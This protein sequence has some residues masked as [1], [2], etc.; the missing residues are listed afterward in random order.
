MPMTLN[1]TLLAKLV[2]W[3][4]GRG[5]QTLNVPDEGS[6]WTVA[7]TVDRADAL[8]CLVWEMTLRR[9]TP[10]AGGDA[11]ALRAWADQAA[12][13]ARGLL[14]MLKVVEVDPERD[15]AIVRSDV[16]SAK[17]EDRFYYEVHLKGSGIAV[18]RRYRGSLA[19]TNPKREQVAFALTH[20]ALAR[21]AADL[22][23]E[24]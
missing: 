16:P 21:L 23:A 13:R 6:G 3:R 18:A 20:E 10:L 9:S 19:G 15:E 5:R 8:G 11:R 1:E 4:P 2:E 7:L 17:G 12:G 22:T 24:K 14:E